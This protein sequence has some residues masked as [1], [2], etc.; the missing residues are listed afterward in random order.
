MRRVGGV[1]IGTPF[2]TSHNC[3][4]PQLPYTLTLF[5]SLVLSWNLSVLGQATDKCTFSLVA[6]VGWWATV[7][8]KEPGT[9]LGWRGKVES[10]SRKHTILNPRFRKYT[11]CLCLRKYK[12]VI[13][14][15]IHSGT[16]LW[17]SA[18]WFQVL[19]ETPIQYNFFTYIAKRV[20]G[21]PAT[22]SS[23]PVR[24]AEQQAGP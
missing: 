11:A 18:N 16:P 8:V 9:K 21:P 20:C 2:Y 24:W 14:R 15:F 12:V 1:C 4:N 22:C 13:F 19:D 7:E 17:T 6:L 3:C 5:L 23:A 10:R